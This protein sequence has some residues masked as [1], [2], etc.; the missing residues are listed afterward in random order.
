MRTF[1][2]LALTCVMLSSVPALAKGEEPANPDKKICPR[3]Q[4]TGSRVRNKPQCHTAAEWKAIEDAN[5]DSSRWYADRR[6]GS[7]SSDRQ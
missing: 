3:D 7:A 4:A 6:G 5:R 1:A 2:T